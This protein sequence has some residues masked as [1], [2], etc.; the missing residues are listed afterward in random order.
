MELEKNKKGFEIKYFG[1][2]NTT[3]SRI[4][5]TDILRNIS[6]YQS[7]DYKIGSVLDQGIKFLESKGYNVICYGEL[8]DSYIVMTDFDFGEFKIK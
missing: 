6:V 2:T 7:Y 5:I 3:S 8:K 1:A 4:K